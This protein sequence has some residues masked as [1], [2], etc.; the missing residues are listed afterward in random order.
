MGSVP[1]SSQEKLDRLYAEKKVTPDEY[2]RLRRSLE[3]DQHQ[4]RTLGTSEYRRRLPWQ[5][6]VSMGV[7]VVAGTIQIPL[8]ITKAPLVAL[9]IL[10]ASV[11]LIYGLY[12]RHRWAFI[13]YL[14]FCL[15]S[16]LVMF[17]NPG[18]VF[19]NLVFGFILLTAYPHFFGDRKPLPR[20]QN[21]E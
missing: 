2:D 21:R 9:T 6:W 20:R 17:T 10:A 13:A 7:L 8:S 18:I 5:V 15:S 16:L 12:Q 11:A 3:M 1:D 14:L 19:V 4:L